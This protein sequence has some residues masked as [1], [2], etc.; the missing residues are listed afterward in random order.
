MKIKYSR[1]ISFLL[2]ISLLFSLSL[3]SCKTN[4]N[5]EN[6]KPGNNTTDGDN[7]KQELPNNNPDKPDGKKEIAFAEMVDFYKIQYTISRDAT[8]SKA[9]KSPLDIKVFDGERAVTVLN[10]TPEA[11]SQKGIITLG[12]KLDIT[13]SYSL[14]IDGYHEKTVVPTFIFDTEEFKN[15]EQEIK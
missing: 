10:I 5:K 12:E 15:L 9:D 11:N 4:R 3:T 8:S 1:M 7:N 6:T 13:K 14:V 2:V